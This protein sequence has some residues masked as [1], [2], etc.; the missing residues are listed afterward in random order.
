[1]DNPKLI[2]FLQTIFYGLVTV[3]TPAFIEALGQGGALYGLLPAGAT[4]VLLFVLNLVDNNITNKTG[5]AFF[6]SVN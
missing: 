1:M 6:G 5:K 2:A 4:G 3:L